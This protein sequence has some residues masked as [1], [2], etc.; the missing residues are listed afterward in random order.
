[1]AQHLHTYN[2]NLSNKNATVSAQRLYEY[3]KT[4]YKN[5]CIT[6]QMEST[7]KGSPDYEMNY[8]FN[9]TG[10]YPAIRGLD[11]MHNDFEGVV[12]RSIE[13][14]KKGGIVTICWH[15]GADFASAYTESQSDDI[16][17]SEAFT[18]GSH[19]YNSLISG[20]DRAVP[21]LMKLQDSDVPVLWRPFH[22]F[23]GKW[24]WWG[25]GDSENFV[26]LW[27][28]MYERYTYHWKLNNLIWVLGYS[29]SG[30]NLPGWYP[31]DEYVDIVGGDCYEHGPNHDLYVKMTEIADSDMPIVFHEC[32]KI[33][34]AT[35]LKETDTPWLYFMTWH[36]EWLTD[37]N[38]LELLKEVYRDDFFITLDKLPKL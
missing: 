12:E 31:G 25:K 37:N 32:G 29:H 24:F 38:P 18:E 20:M 17:W 2:G 1:M 26:K 3:L 23:D 15:T 5:N 8:I 14:W 22:E 35:E 10:K 33:P 13:W 16:N 36:T 28:L 6:G 9:N 21:Y 4:T 11:F 30:T 34:T 19:T 27:K 7:W